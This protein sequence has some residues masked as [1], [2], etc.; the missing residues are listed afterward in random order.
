MAD[1]PVP[2]SPVEL[3]DQEIQERA[4]AMFELDQQIRAGLNKGREGLWEAA[5]AMYVFDEQ[6]GWSALS[7]E[8]VV[9]YCADPE[10]GISRSTYYRMIRA[11]HETVVLRKIDFDRVKQLDRSKVD[12]VLTKV[13]TGEKKIDDALDDAEALGLRDLR[14]LYWGPQKNGKPAEEEDVSP[15]T[16]VHD[17]PPPADDETGQVYGLD[18]EEVEL[19]DGEELVDEGE[20]SVAGYENETAPQIFYGEVLEAQI[21]EALEACRQGLTSPS[22][23]L[24]RVA[25]DK[26]VNVLQAMLDAR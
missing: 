3:T 20:E 17:D 2:A 9:H 14:D 6:A 5:K 19:V 21:E 18:D 25:L 13:A 1:H 8:S 22:D 4:Q 10:I 23:L 11:Y 24:R 26:A 15:T 7:Y 16:H 12:I